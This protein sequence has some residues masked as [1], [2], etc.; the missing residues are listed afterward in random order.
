MFDSNGGIW[1]H[2]TAEDGV[3]D[4]NNIAVSGF[5]RESEVK[6]FPKTIDCTLDENELTGH[7][8]YLRDYNVVK[9]CEKSPVCRDITKSLFAG[10]IT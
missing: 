9:E 7:S 8:Y 10:R 5:I 4:Q 3:V 1:Y 6:V 2:G